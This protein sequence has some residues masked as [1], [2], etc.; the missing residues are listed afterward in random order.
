[1]MPKCLTCLVHRKFVY[2]IAT[3][4]QIVPSETFL[5]QYRSIHDTKKRENPLIYG[6][7][8]LLGITIAAQ[9]GGQAYSAYKKHSSK[10]ATAESENIISNKASS[11]KNEKNSENSSSTTGSSS[12]FFDSSWFAKNFYDGGFEDK[13][14]KREAALV[15]GVRESASPERIKDA[16]RKILLLNHPDRGGSAFIAA[17]VNEA[18][19]LLL[20]GK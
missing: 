8:V 15:L 13:M 16:H 3:V 6:G 10:E 4:Q 19:D 2:N 18:K 5:T 17:K 11:N 12:S 9:Y 14:S 20:K 1:M 7:V